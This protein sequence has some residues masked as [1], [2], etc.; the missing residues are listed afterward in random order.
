MMTRA[1]CAGGRREADRI[2]LDHQR[3]TLDVRER[4]IAGI[5]ETVHRIA[6]N[7]RAALTQPRFEA[8]TQRLD[9]IAIALLQRG[10]EF[11]RRTEPDD[12]RD[13]LG[14]GARSALVP[15]AGKQR[16][17]IQTLVD[18]QRAGALRAVDLVRRQR[19]R[20][21]IQVGEAHGNLPERLDRVGVHHGLCRARLLAEPRDRL[22]HAG[23][24]VREHHRHDAGWRIERQREVR[25]AHDAIRNRHPARLRSSP[26]APVASPARGRTDARSR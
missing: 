20:I 15:A 3:F 1:R 14:A 19:H 21:D 12:R 10:G 25:L 9:V 13:I 5:R 23:L 8:R 26:V 11:R 17:Q 4:E 2:E 22:D 18:N 6:E 16:Q 7:P 24:V